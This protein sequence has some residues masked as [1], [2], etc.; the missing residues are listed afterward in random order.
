MKILLYFGNNEPFHKS[1]IGRAQFHQQKAIELM[2][3]S[4]TH[5]L[6]DKYD[7]VHINVL[8]FKSYRLLKKAKKKHIP[9]IVHGHSTFEDFRNSFRYWKIMSIYYYSVIKLLYSHADLI[10]T[11]TNYSKNLIENYNYNVKVLALSNGIDLE[12][13][14]YSQEKINKFKQYFNITN[15]KVIIGIGFPF[16]RKGI[17]EFIEIAKHYENNKN[18]KF[19]W[20]GYLNKFLVSHK[21]NK[22]MKHKP[23]NLIFPGYIENEIIKGAL[24]YAKCL[25]FPSYEE[26]EGIVVLEALASNC[27]AL[28]RDIGVY[29]DWLTDSYDCLKANSNDEFIKKIDYILNDENK[30]KLDQIKRN[31]YNTVSKL[32][33]KN[34]SIK[35]K[36]IY[37]SLV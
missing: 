5:K 36:E 2:N 3:Y 22:A 17:L 6:K 16:Q 26:T 27:I 37:D 32:S 15:E 19:I 9:V 29:K 35:L 4:Y 20:F 24:L 8:S 31:G 14:K 18:L 10:I 34:I 30:E 13:Y 23:Q 33:I 12:N 25:L 1:G 28:V 11:P 7:I 21:I